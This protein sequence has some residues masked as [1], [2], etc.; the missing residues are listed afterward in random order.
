MDHTFRNKTISGVIWKAMESGGNQ[1]VKFVISVMLARMLDPQNYTTLALLLIFVNIADVLVK[2]GFATAL[3]QRKDADNTD[4]SSVL[5]LTLVLAAVFYGVL[6]FSA[7]AV[8]RFYEEPLI[9]PALRIVA[10]M[11]FPGAFNSVQGAIVMRKLEFRKFCIA[12]LGATL[13]SGA[14]GI[15]MAYAGY[16]VWTL[17][18]QQM[19]SSFTN[20]LLLWL[21]DRWRPALVFSIKR[22][23][24]LFSFG[25]KL[26]LSSLLDTGY[27]SLSS[28][29][30]GKRYIGDSLAF[31]NR[32]RQYPDMIANN[33]TSIALSVLF[34]AYAAHQDN[35]ERVRGMVRKTNRST[36]LMIFPMMAGLAA[37]A[38]PFVRVLLTEKWLPSVPYLQMMCIVF[39]LYPV[40]ATDLQAMNALG[41][42]DLYLKTEIIKKVFGI[43]ALVVSV[44]AF[45]TP[46]AIAGAVVLTAVFSMFVTM[47]V[48]KQLFAYRWR[49]QIWDMMPPILLSGVMWGAVYAVSFIPIPELPLLILQIVCGIAVYLGLAVLLRLESISY[50]WTS[51]KSY[52]T[53]NRKP[54]E[55]PC[56]PDGCDPNDIL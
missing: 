8:S 37:V 56:G 49:D 16:G 47:V 9:I 5:W 50:L 32:G 4:F 24:S 29:V 18:A 26:L 12:T 54:E 22:A 19:I 23:G 1:L 3:I 40:E 38:T 33:L 35:K 52:F 27:N 44:F 25:W 15:Y 39:A 31:Y 20:V 14:V 53:K 11:L 48:M 10:L 55:P 6:F 17:V 41:R 36:A 51:M 45:N 43:L 7:P 2:R 42:S 30:I 13:L 46:V 34:P 21:M 28:L